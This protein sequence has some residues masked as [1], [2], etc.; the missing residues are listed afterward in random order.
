MVP[1][2]HQWSFF[3][4]ASTLHIEL[5]YFLQISSK[6]DIC[7]FQDISPNY[8]NT[9][10]F[11]NCWVPVYFINYIQVVSVYIPMAHKMCLS[12]DL[13]EI[14]HGPSQLRKFF[15]CN[16]ISHSF[17]WISP[18]TGMFSQTFWLQWLLLKKISLWF[19]NFFT[20]QQNV[21]Y[22]W[23]MLIITWKFC[24]SSFQVF[25]E[26]QYKSK[27]PY[28]YCEPSPIWVQ[29]IVWKCV[30]IPNLTWNMTGLM[31]DFFTVLMWFIYQLCIHL[32]YM[33]LE[34]QSWLWYFRIFSFCNAGR[35]SFSS[36]I[37]CIDLMKWSILM[38]L[39]I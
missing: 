7:S 22:F 35:T 27:Y 29:Q 8:F 4:N 32:P 24:W 36:L 15:H 14:F 31:N 5:W 17:L 38:V 23:F 21:L 37:W 10:V 26:F 12:K 18:V 20:H 33:C 1:L 25:Y 19:F 13:S 30:A 11:C 16:I 34:L 39:W 9:R 3:L 28:N 6:N 2:E